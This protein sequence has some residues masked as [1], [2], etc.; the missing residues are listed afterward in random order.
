YADLDQVLESGDTLAILPPVSG[1]SGS[2]DICELTRD[3]IDSRKL[4]L[5]VL[6]PGDGAVVTFDGVTRNQSRG[7][8][9][10]FLEYEAYEPMAIKTMRQIVD[11]ARRKWDIDRIAII[12]RLGRVDI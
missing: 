6:E 2:D 8:A 1:G 11:E 12:H 5:R 10:R 9:V 3:E 4:A 7:R